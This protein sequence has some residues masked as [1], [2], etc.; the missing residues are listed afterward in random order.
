M[1][2]NIYSLHSTI[3]NGEAK[4]HM[5]SR[6]CKACDTWQA[7]RSSKHPSYTTHGKQVAG[8]KHAAYVTCQA[9]RQFPNH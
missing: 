1:K 8:V 9:W 3:L 7:T 5:T 6:R 2:L 4:C